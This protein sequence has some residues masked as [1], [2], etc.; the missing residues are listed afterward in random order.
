MFLGLPVK[1]HP[2]DY[3]RVLLRG[4]NTQFL[5]RDFI[6]MVSD[7][8]ILK[9]C[10][11]LNANVIEVFAQYYKGTTTIFFSSFFVPIVNFEIIKATLN[12]FRKTS[13]LTLSELHQMLALTLSKFFRV[14]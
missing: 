14:A 3:R 12:I 10:Q 13:K 1:W 11:I 2:L 4:M 7:Y 5:V 9:E 6:F 8:H